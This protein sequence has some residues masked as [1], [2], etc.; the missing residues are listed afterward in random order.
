MKK[1]LLFAFAIFMFNGMIAQNAITIEP[2]VATA[3]DEITLY[4]DVTKTCPDS[5]L[6]G[7][8]SVMMHSGVTIDGEGWQLAVPFDGTAVN[9]QKPKLTK[10]MP[11]AYITPAN[12]TAWDEIT[13]T[14]DVTKSCPDSA[15]LEA[16]SIMMHSGV[17]IDGAAWQNVVDFDG[18][19]ANG[20][21][22]KLTNNGDHTWSIT[23]I[24]AEFYGIDEGTDVT[25]LNFVFNNGTW[26]AEGKAFDEEGACVDFELP[27]DGTGTLSNL[28][29][30][31]FIPAEYYGIEEG[32][33]VEALDMVFNNGTWDAEGKDFDEN[34][35]CT[36]FKLDLSGVGIFDKP[37]VATFNIFPNPADNQITIDQI[38]D[39]SKIEI[40]NVVGALV[41]TVD[42][43]TS[44][45]ISIDVSGLNNGV[46]FISVYNQDGVQTSKFVKE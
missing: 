6:L 13:L 4:L 37:A 29:M 40:F 43:I 19:G 26:D 42:E 8:D 35:E 15:L 10:V 27:L 21:A 23:F 39:A 41:K 30:I 7:V 32:T 17:T 12:A 2:E 25:A 9:G 36:D 22:P 38:K 28:W 11:A 44:Q 31:T 14:L 5:A 24:P 20:M 45:Q 18:M 1:L 33:N 46:Y 16:D 34:M 3:W